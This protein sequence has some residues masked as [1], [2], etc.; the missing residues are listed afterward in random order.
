MHAPEVYY[1]VLEITTVAKKTPLIS[2]YT[3]IL[4]TW[5]YKGLFSKYSNV[6]WIGK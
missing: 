2:I 3:T 4:W 6:F 1:M 5:E